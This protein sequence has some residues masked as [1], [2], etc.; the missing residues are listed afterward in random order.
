MKAVRLY[1]I[2]DIRLEEIPVPAVGPDDVLV[3]MKACGI[4]GSDVMK[5]YVRKKAPV[6]M[7]HE[8][9]GVIVEIGARV[10][11]FQ[12][13]D[14]VFVHHHAPCFDCKYC[15]KGQYSLCPVWKASH[16]E[17]GGLAEYFRVPAQN[18]H[19]DTLKLPARLS[20]EDGA[21]IEP[22][23]CVVKS[24]KRARLT[25]GD[26]MVVLGLGVMGQMHILLA[27]YQGA[28]QIIGVDCVPFRL[29]KAMK[30]GADAT[31][32]FKNEPVVEK[33]REVTRGEMADVVIVCP[34]SIDA[35]R[36]GIECAGKGATVLLF[37][38]APEDQTLA[39]QP[40]RLYFNEIDLICSYSCGPDDTRE[41]LQIIE[42]GVVTA[43]KLV[44]HRFS[45]NKCDQAFEVVRRGNSSLKV[46]VLNDN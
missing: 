18:L 17:P 3:K 37:T 10:E 45:L 31:I 27:K 13:G 11:D 39:I 23:A 1:D 4:C 15:R 2:D 9:A 44:T 34:D 29:E 8:P 43:S 35:M 21:L 36:M 12:I 38:P 5:W 30:F 7:G 40:F 33:L 19:G 22:L 16:I 24:L 26:R 32:D 42:S 20:F 28:K 41:A 46:I 6:F 25:P 14:R